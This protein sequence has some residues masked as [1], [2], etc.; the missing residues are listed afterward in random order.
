MKDFTIA[1]I[2]PHGIRSKLEPHIIR[3]IEACDFEIGYLA[4]ETFSRERAKGYFKEYKTM[5]FYEELISY[6]TS[7]SSMIL[8]LRKKNAVAEFNRII[9]I[10]KAVCGDII[11]ASASEEKAVRDMLYFFDEEV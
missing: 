2:K 7:G 5:N 10:I 4:N 1:L 3:I 9:S 6:M 8:V 11:E